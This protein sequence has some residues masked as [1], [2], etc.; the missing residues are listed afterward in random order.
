MLEDVHPS[1]S[2]SVV[3]LTLMVVMM[4]PLGCKEVLSASLSKLRS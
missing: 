3:P 4:E 1:L 2:A